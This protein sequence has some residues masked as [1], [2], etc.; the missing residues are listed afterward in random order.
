MRKTIKT[1][2]LMSSPS[3]QADRAE[4]LAERRGAAIAEPL[5]ARQILGKSA[6][7]ASS[8]IETTR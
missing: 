8:A 4:K 1:S 7:S 3:K 5:Q 6:P 2:R